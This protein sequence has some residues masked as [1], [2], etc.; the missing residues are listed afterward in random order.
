MTYSHPGLHA[1][2]VLIMQTSKSINQARKQ[3]GVEAPKFTFQLA[4][5]LS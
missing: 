5:D 4:I 2:E 3:M 1:S